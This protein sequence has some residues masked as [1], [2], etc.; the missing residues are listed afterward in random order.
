MKKNQK[1]IGGIPRESAMMAAGYCLGLSRRESISLDKFDRRIL[2]YAG[3]ALA[4]SCKELWPEW[5]K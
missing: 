3:K 4:A 1:S 2:K 5:F